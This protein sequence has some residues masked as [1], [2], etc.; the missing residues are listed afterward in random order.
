[1][2][3]RLSVFIVLML[4]ILPQTGFAAGKSQY[5]FYGFSSDAKYC[6]F[7]TYGYYDGS[8][9]PYSNIYIVD[10]IKNVY[11][12]S[13]I[14]LCDRE[15]KYRDVN[16]VRAANMKIASTYFKKYKIEKKD[17]GKSIFIHP[18]DKH[19]TSFK[20]GSKNY[21]LKL[22]EKNFDI[23]DTTFVKEKIFELQLI[24]PNGQV[25]SLQKDTRLPKSR[26]F[27]FTY[28]LLTGY[29]KDSKLVVFI[30]HEG[31]GFEGSDFTQMVVTG[32][33]D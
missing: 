16:Q 9:F 33:L 22:I 32:T 7:E 1:M 27:P 13:P 20:V 30:E 15:E 8:G 26:R 24:K 10:T 14:I 21:K 23:K 11:A 25:K 31:Y 6:A 19:L 17:L 12:V 29:V 28:N 4:F 2:K 5:V 3:S 18:K